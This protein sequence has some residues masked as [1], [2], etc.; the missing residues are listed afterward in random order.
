M[1]RCLLLVMIFFAACNKSPETIET[2]KPPLD[3]STPDNAVKS[4]WK[5]AIWKDTSTVDTSTYQ[6]FT[7]NRIDKQKLQRTRSLE[8]ARKKHAFSDNTITDV[9]VKSESYAVVEAKEFTEYSDK[10]TDTRYVLSWEQ[11]HWKIDDYQHKC[12]TCDGTGMQTD[13]DQQLKD[14]QRGL[15]RTDP[16]KKCEQCKA[17]GWKS[18]FPEPE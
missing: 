1:T 10:P 12:Y 15:Y 11:G 4:F 9:Q 16:K 3:F 8:K 7:R 14:I 18:Y 5:F 17:T 2:G 13:Y 6:L